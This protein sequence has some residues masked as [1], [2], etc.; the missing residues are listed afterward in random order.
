MS[1]D[2]NTLNISLNTIRWWFIGLCSQSRTQEANSVN[3]IRDLKVSTGA[4]QML[5]YSHRAYKALCQHPC[6]H[7]YKNV[8]LCSELLFIVFSGDSTGK[9]WHISYELARGLAF[10][11]K[12]CLLEEQLAT[13]TGNFSHLFKWHIEAALLHEHIYLCLCAVLFFM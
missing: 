7:F 11:E 3:V 5:P 8:F 9:G 10:W 1:M 2:P 4:I 12:Y 6:F 13:L